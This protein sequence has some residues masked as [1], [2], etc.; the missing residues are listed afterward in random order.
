[1][2][3]CIPIIPLRIADVP[4]TPHME[5]FIGSYQWLDALTPP[6]KKHLPK[7][8]Q[9]VQSLLNKNKPGQSEKPNPYLQS[10]VA[11]P[12]IFPHWRVRICNLDH[13]DN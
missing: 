9:A 10:F 2:N 3:C 6:L 13:A 4:L 1:M 7:L 5:Y 12:G 8:T 11:I